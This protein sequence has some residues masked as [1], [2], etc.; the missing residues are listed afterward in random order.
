MKEWC[1]DE[2]TKWKKR[3]LRQIGT[4]IRCF[5][6][7]SM[8]VLSKWQFWNLFGAPDV[9]TLLSASTTD[10]CSVIQEGEITVENCAHRGAAICRERHTLS[11]GRNKHGHNNSAPLNQVSAPDF[12]SQLH[13]DS[14]KIWWIWT[15][16]RLDLSDL[17]S[18]AGSAHGEPT[19]H[20]HLLHPLLLSK[21]L[22]HNYFISP[23]ILQSLILQSS[24]LQK[25]ST[26]YILIYQRAYWLIDWIG[27]FKMTCGQFLDA[28]N[29][30]FLFLIL[31][32]MYKNTSACPII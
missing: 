12:N 15:L 13:Q 24:R 18:E 28:K 11:L 21:Y 30:G 29:S 14:P 3:E 32:Y 7:L 31:M 2:P 25:E 1:I 20:T 6:V 27:I 16:Q 26:K 4:Q 5:D 22:G 10:I 19:P 8:F 9:L 17:F 23:N